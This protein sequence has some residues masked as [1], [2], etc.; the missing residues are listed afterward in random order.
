MIQAPKDRLDV[1]KLSKRIRRYVVN[2]IVWPRFWIMREDD[3]RWGS[4]KRSGSSGLRISR[5]YGYGSS[6]YIKRYQQKSPDNMKI[7]DLDRIIGYLSKG[8]WSSYILRQ[9]VHNYKLSYGTG[10]KVSSET[11][12]KHL[13]DDL[14]K[15]SVT[16]EVDGIKCK[17]MIV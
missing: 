15:V 12:N 14:T 5:P 13:K 8:N 3:A 6:G 16:I 1:T 11:F 9:H 17:H 10:R 7:E 4:R 2:D